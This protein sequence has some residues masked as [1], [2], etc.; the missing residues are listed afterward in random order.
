M[1]KLGEGIARNKKLTNFNMGLDSN[2][3]SNLDKIGEGICRNNILTEFY[4]D[5]RSN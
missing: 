3:I 4:M 5:L 1:D 2:Y